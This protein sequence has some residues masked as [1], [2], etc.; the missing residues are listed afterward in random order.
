M[1]DGI[2][3]I[4]QMVENWQR[5]PKAIKLTHYLH[6]FSRTWIIAIELDTKI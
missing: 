5:K 4:T 6:T 2:G 3:Q 1:S